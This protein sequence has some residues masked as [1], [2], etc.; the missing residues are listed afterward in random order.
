MV[1]SESHY[2]GPRTR[3]RRHIVRIG[4]PLTPWIQ[5]LGHRKSDIQSRHE[6]QFRSNKSS[7]LP[8]YLVRSHGS[9]GS[10]FLEPSRKKYRSVG[11]TWSGAAPLSHRETSPPAIEN[12]PSRVAM[13]DDFA[14]T[15]AQCSRQNLPRATVAPDR[16]SM[17]PRARSRRHMVKIGTP[18]TVDPAPRPS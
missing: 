13:C 15:K 11:V 3:S 10:S 6:R 5:P 9:L 16:H 14:Q 7:L 12:L 1:A 8:P 4:T 18:H 17:C 2:V